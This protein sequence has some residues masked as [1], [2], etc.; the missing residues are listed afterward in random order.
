[1]EL[2]AGFPHPGINFDSRN[3]NMERPVLSDGPFHIGAG[4]GIRTRDLMITNQALYQL[5]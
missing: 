5:S 1:M 4:C 2:D 3:S